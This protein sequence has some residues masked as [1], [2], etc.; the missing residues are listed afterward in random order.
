M[1]YANLT[2]DEALRLRPGT[3][4]YDTVVAVVKAAEEAEDERAKRLAVF[5]GNAVWGKSS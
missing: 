1:H 4:R 5:T 2:M 3:D